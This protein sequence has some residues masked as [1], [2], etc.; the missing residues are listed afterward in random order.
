MM[1]SVHITTILKNYYV[2]HR[3]KN[4]WKTIHMEQS[5]AVNTF[6]RKTKHL[7]KLRIEQTD[8]FYHDMLG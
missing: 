4:I 7:D 8:Q 3:K 6:I 5:S 2:L 1:A